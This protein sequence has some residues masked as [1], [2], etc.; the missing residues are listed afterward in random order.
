MKAI[1]KF[2]FVPGE[3]VED[4]CM[5]KPGGYHPV[6]LGDIFQSQSNSKYRVLQN[7]DSGSFATVWLATDVLKGYDIALIC[8]SSFYMIFLQLPCFGLDYLLI[9]LNRRYVALKVLTADKTANGNE[10]QLL[11]WLGVQSREHPLDIIMSRIYWT[12]SK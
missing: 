3:D 9:G 6:K 4:I 11:T 8:L 1:Q 7:L 2:Q 10:V 12:A 5:Y